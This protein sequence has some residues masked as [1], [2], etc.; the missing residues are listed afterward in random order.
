LNDENGQIIT[1]NAS[2]PSQLNELKKE[3]SEF[4]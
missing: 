1:D 3:I 2:R 4:L